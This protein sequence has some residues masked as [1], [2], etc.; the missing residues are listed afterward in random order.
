MGPIRSLMLYPIELR[1]HIVD[2]FGRT[3]S[4]TTIQAIF[5]ALLILSGC[6]NGSCPN[7]IGR[8]APNFTVQGSERAISLNQFRG[9]VD[10]RLN[11]AAELSAP[12]QVPFAH[13]FSSHH[14]PLGTEWKVDPKYKLSAISDR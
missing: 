1:G 11:R 4:L 3:H 12:S 10:K 6:C 14:F 9:Q 8:A 7:G 13:V 2:N 5:A